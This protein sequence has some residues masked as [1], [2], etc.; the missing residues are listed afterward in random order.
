MSELKTISFKEVTISYLLELN[1]KAD[2]LLSQTEIT[3]S[4]VHKTYIDVRDTR[5]KIEKM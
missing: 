3:L 4:E 2:T 5:V 1:N